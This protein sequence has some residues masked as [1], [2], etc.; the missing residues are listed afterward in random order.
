MKTTRG[1]KAQRAYARSELADMTPD[2]AEQWVEEQV[3]DVASAKRARKV[4][5]HARVAVARG[6]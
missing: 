6:Q 2:Q 5:A 4:L 1:M 3:H